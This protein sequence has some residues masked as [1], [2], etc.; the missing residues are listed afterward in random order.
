MILFPAIDIRNG[1]CVR[2]IQGDYKK[3]KVYSDSP[4]EIAA[5]WEDKRAEYLHIVDLD[6]A[7]TGESDNS[8]LIKDIAEQARIPVQVG[9]GIR[10]FNKVNDYLSAG[11]DRVVVG[12]AAIRDKAFLKRSIREYGSQIAVSIDARNGYAATDGWTK[13]S[14]VKATDLIMEL[15]QLGVKTIIYTDIWK[16]GMLEGPNFNEL[17]AIIDTTTTIDVIASGGVTTKQDVDQLKSMNLYGVII[18][19]ALY[20]GTLAFETILEEDDNVN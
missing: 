12:T 8:N 18:G 1:K 17:Q 19:K 20:D 6:G 2:L 11:V 5:Q 7:K 15:E 10:S 3:E 9:G 16:D 4:L 14:D 13:T